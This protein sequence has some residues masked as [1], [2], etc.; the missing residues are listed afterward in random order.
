MIGMKRVLTVLVVALLADIAACGGGGGGGGSSM[1]AEAQ[2]LKSAPAPAQP[3]NIATTQLTAMYQGVTYT[4]MYSETPNSGTAT[5]DGHQASS[6]TISITVS[7]NGAPLAAETSIA[8]F[9]QNPFSPLGLME[10]INGVSYD[11]I[12]TTQNPLPAMLSVGDSGT[13]LT[14]TFYV[15]GNPATVGTLTETW[16]VAANDADT[17]LFTVA[18]TGTLN[19]ASVSDTVTYS[20][21][22]EGTIA[23]VSVTVTLPGGAG[24]LTF[25]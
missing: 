20:V 12:F 21:D 13:L 24:T 11:L 6:S 19:G 9:L 7:A 14:G 17:V 25:S 22:A 5:F 8:Y 1:P 3:Y 2:S 16:S 23:I 4:A 10:T 15:A 18:S